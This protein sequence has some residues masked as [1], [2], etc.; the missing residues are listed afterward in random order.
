MTVGPIVGQFVDPSAIFPQ[1]IRRLADRLVSDIRAPE[2]SNLTPENESYF[3]INGGNT[4]INTFN[5]TGSGD[6]SDC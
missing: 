5:G 6:V 3:S 4:N 1:P 2:I